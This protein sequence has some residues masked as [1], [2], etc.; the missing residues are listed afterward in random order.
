MAIVV[1][2]SLETSSNF[3]S[4]VQ[5]AATECD[6]SGTITS[7]GGQESDSEYQRII[8]WV[9]DAY[10]VIQNKHPFRW[11][12]LWKE[13]ETQLE[14]GSRLF[15]P[16]AD[17]NIYPMKW[18]QESIKIYRTSG[19]VGGEMFIPWMEYTQ[20]RDTYLYGTIITTYPRHYTFR[21][22]RKV[23]FNSVLDAIYTFSG[24]Y[25]S[26]AERLVDDEDEPSMP[27]QY[28]MAIVWR[29]VMFYASFEEA[30][31]LFNTAQ[32]NYLTL[33][34][35]IENTELDDFQTAGALC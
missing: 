21:R 15:D 33:L 1:Q 8:N 27:V 4:L 3:L 12:W 5:R 28:H 34:K 31:V 14:A 29:A 6:I 24:E 9:A 18:E 16:I 32:A 19:G 10:I 7:V 35:Q 26:T 23:M 22:D 2:S 17:W 13:F 30:G 20:F 11:R 25:Y